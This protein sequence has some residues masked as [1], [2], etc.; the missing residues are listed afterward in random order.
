MKKTTF[1]STSFIITVMAGCILLQTSCRKSLLDQTPTV[2][3]SPA[4]FWKTEA[5]ATSGLLGLYAAARPCFD[6]DYYMDGQAEYFRCRGTSTTAGNLRLGDAYNGGNYNPT[7]YASSFDNMYKYLY[8]TV[9]RANYVIDNVTKMQAGGGSNGTSTIL[10]TIQ[11]ESR[12]LRGLAYFKLISMWGDVPYYTFSPNTNADVAS[13]PRVAIGKVK[14][15]ILADLTY[16]FNNLP[17]T[18][19][20]LGRASKV[21]A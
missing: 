15:S 13:L 10:Q 1:I 17:K 11:G 12:L 21:A 19:S 18:A 2:N 7:G 4:T 14:D 8:G 9:D 5:D 16:A 20:A 3:P 6:R